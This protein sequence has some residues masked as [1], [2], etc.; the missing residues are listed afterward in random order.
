M[1]DILEHLVNP[2][3]LLKELRNSLDVNGYV[4]IFI[5][6]IAYYILRLMLLR[7]IF[8]YQDHGILDKTHLRFYT[9]YTAREMVRSAGYK[10]DMCEGYGFGF[11]FGRLSKIPVINILYNLITKSLLKYPNIFASHTLIKASLEFHK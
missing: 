2:V 1:A 11:P 9:F 3:G 10:I 8:K 4:I 7:G 5:P 6:N